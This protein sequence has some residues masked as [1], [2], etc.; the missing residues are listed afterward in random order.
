[1]KLL[2][3]AV[4]IVAL[5]VTIASAQPNTGDQVLPN[6]DFTMYNY[7]APDQP[8]NLAQHH[9]EN[10]CVALITGSIC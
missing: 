1:M 10:T 4:C 6:H 9:D 3:K 8:W 2:V 5:F 7:L